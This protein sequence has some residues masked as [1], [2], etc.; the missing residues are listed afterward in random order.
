[1]LKADEMEYCFFSRIFIKNHILRLTSSLI[2]KN[3]HILKLNCFT[4]NDMWFFKEKA[5]FFMK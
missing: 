4:K 3:T 2:L 5:R 1:M